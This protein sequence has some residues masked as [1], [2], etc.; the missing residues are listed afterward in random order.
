MLV[1]SLSNRNPKK[2]Q[3][4]EELGKQRTTRLLAFPVHISGNKDMVNSNNQV[5]W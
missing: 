5:T 1:V 2:D 4:M 3:L